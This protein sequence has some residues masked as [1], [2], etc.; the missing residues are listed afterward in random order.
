MRCSEY[1]SDAGCYDLLEDTGWKIQAVIS[2][3]PDLP[4]VAE[5][6]AGNCRSCYRCRYTTIFLVVSVVSVIGDLVF[7]VISGLSAKSVIV[8]AVEIKTNR[9]IGY[10]WAVRTIRLLPFHLSEHVLHVLA[11]NRAEQVVYHHTFSHSY[12][13]NLFVTMTS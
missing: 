5:I 1:D 10:C 13:K 12:R 7:S 4:T 3:V 2:S 11:L 6:A 8:H 9:G